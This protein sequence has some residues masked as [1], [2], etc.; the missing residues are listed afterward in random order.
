M[1][2]DRSEVQDPVALAEE[3]IKATVDPV[4]PEVLTGE[5]LVYL[6]DLRLSGDTNMFGAG[7]YL[8][9]EFVDLS[10]REARAVLSYWMKTFAARHPAE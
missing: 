3:F 9:V 7:S 5:H 10:R 8:E 4:A 2:E 6:D 1:D